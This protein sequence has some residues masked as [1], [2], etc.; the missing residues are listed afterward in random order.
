[1]APR[2][3][4]SAGR[5]ANFPFH[6]R[7]LKGFFRLRKIPAFKRWRSER[8]NLY[9]YKLDS[10]ATAMDHALQGPVGEKAA[11]GLWKNEPLSSLAQRSS[12][13]F[14]ACTLALTA[15]FLLSSSWLQD[16]PTTG[17]IKC[18][19]TYL[20]R[21]QSLKTS[22]QKTKK[23]EQSVLYIGTFQTLDREME[24]QALARGASFGA[25]GDTV[26]PGYKEFGYTIPLL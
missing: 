17:C 20:K 5:V 9:Q 11:I 16:V 12:C 10:F 7:T 14:G 1:M 25:T 19:S 21:D 23:K 26:E 3:C 2:G 6:L 8:S 18:S 24:P 15:F 13:E 22:H 4:Y